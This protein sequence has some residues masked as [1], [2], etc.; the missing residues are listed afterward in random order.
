MAMLDMLTGA[1][2]APAPAAAQAPPPVAPGMMDI[3]DMMGAAMPVQP[4][5][6]VAP[7]NGIV[8]IDSAHGLRVSLS[9]AHGSPPGH[10]VIT[11]T[12]S[13]VGSSGATFTD[14]MIQ[15]AVPKFIQMRIDPASGSH[16]PVGGSVTQCLH[17][18]NSLHG[19][20][21]VAVRLR[22]AFK[23]PGA[24]Q[25]TVEQGQVSFPIE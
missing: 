7:A 4:Q 22:V 14:V 19:Q 6:A 8:G 13:N 24:A 10:S 5:P 21:Q 16:L 25:E 11:A 23:L 18:V 9:I 12:A 17:V 15:A 20:K 1:P 2:A 3:M